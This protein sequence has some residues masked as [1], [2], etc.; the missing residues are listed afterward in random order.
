MPLLGYEV[1]KPN[2][3]DAIQKDFVFKLRFKNHVYFFRAES[4][5]TFDR[6][7]SNG[8]CTLGMF[9]V[10]QLDEEDTNFVVGT[11]NPC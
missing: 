3:E 6:Y 10:V 8:T 2:A 5:Y 1:Q 7:A 11:V 9:C 4:Q